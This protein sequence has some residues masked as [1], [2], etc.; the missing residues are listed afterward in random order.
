MDAEKKHPLLS[1]LVGS[2]NWQQ[3]LVFTRTK[4]AAD[5]LARELTADGLNT[6]AVHGD[7]SQGARER[8]LEAFR[9]GEVR[10]LV[11]TDVAARGWIS[12]A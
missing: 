11:A 7:K 1:Y 10:V 5:Y 2:N 4:Q 6:K 9:E 3:V 8:E 12:T